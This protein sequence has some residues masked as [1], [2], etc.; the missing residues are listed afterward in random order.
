MQKKHVLAFPK[1]MPHLEC[2]GQSRIVGV[3]TASGARALLSGSGQFL[4]AL[5]LPSASLP[6]VPSFLH[7]LG[8]SGILALLR[9]SFERTAIAASR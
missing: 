8:G 4:K 1:K 5:L 6:L 7:G 9:S 3:E 2:F